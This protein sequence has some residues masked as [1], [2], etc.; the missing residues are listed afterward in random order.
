MYVRARPWLPILG[1]SLSQRAIAAGA[2]CAVA[3]CAAGKCK[4]CSDTQ[5]ETNRKPRV[6]H[7]I[8]EPTVEQK[9]RAGW[10]CRQLCRVSEQPPDKRDL[11]CPQAKPVRRTGAA[12][13][14]PHHICAKRVTPPQVCTKCNDLKPAGEF[15]RDKTKADGLQFRCK[16]PRALLGFKRPQQHAVCQL[17]G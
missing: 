13:A 3:L 1:C 2:S 8:Q 5:A 16:V 6:R 15:N 7:N 9:V 10:L 11:G 17:R 12:V 14:R 4:L